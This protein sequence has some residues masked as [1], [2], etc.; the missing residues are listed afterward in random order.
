MEYCRDHATGANEKKYKLLATQAFKEFNALEFGE[1]TKALIVKNQ[2]EN[3][4]YLG[5]SL[6]KKNCNSLRKMLHVQYN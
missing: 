4:G 1:K 6:T 2:A 5:D 3:G